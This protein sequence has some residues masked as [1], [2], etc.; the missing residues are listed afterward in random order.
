LW[1]GNM[2]K[3]NHISARNLPSPGLL[4]FAT[5]QDHRAGGWDAVPEQQE[6]ERL[7]RSLYQ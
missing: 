7:W 4:P 1:I 5:G 6:G 2:S 3:E